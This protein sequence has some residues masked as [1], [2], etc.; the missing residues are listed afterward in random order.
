MDFT[1]GPI[2]NH[3]VYYRCY[4]F[5]F[6]HLGPLHR[7]TKSPKVDDDLQCCWCSALYS[8]LALTLFA[9]GGAYMPPCHVFAYICANT[10][11]S[12]LK[13]TWHFPII[14]LEKS[15]VLFTPYNYLVLQKRNKVWRKFP[16]FIRGEPYNL[17]WRPH[18]PVKNY[19]S[20]TFFWGGSGHCHFMNSLEY[21][22]SFLD[23][24]TKN[25]WNHNPNQP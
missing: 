24:I 11:T 2:H 4:L 15:S 16:K 1:L 20:H 5:D 8:T 19:K 9:P 21:G 22:T 13:K 17:G 25:I 14:S 3:I 7:R 18:Q 23:K 6:A 10:C 12:G